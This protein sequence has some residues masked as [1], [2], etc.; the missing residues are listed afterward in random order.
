MLIYEEVMGSDGMKCS[1]VWGWGHPVG[2]NCTQSR[3]EA[4]GEHGRAEF[5]QDC[6]ERV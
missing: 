4:A 2:G 3:A 6:D 5:Q 1:R